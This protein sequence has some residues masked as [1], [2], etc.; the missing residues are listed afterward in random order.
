MAPRKR[1]SGVLSKGPRTE[2]ALLLPPDWEKVEELQSMLD[3]QGTGK[4]P[5][6]R[7]GLVPLSALIEVREVFQPRHQGGISLDALRVDGHI[8][9]LI[10]E[11][12]DNAVTQ[13]K[14]FDAIVVL[15]IA[16]SLF[17][18]DGHC[19]NAAYRA[20]GWEKPVPVSSFLKLK[21]VRL[22]NV[23]EA[24]NYSRA[25]NVGKA[26]Q[27]LTI[28]DRREAAWGMVLSGARYEDQALTSVEIE[29]Q[30]GYSDTRV[31]FMRGIVHEWLDGGSEVAEKLGDLDV[32]R[33]SWK[34]VTE[35]L[36]A[37]DNTPW[38]NTYNE[39]GQVDTYM[40]KLKPIIPLLQ[41][42]KILAKALVKG[43]GAIV[44]ELIS[45]LQAEVPFTGTAADDSEF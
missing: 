1:G 3:T 7:G 4:D 37:D 6:W 31:N 23:V 15:P 32:W 21:D 36:N 2:H 29:K 34:Q 22:G 18:V 33:S 8:R 17:I 9:D 11:L 19:R 26:K 41:H 44:P 24:I 28:A 42:P 13:K 10:K 16:G 38:D 27:S 12:R 25:A 35:R 20:V 30:S 5:N 40:E 45:A 14:G 39:E 43:Y